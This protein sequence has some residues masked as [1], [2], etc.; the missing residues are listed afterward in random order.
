MDLVGT[1]T[2]T[3]RLPLRIGLDAGGL[4]VRGIRAGAHA[5]E[6]L[7]AGDGG[8]EPRAT[9]P[10]VER[11]PRSERRPRSQ[12]HPRTA[13]PSRP[14][15]AEPAEPV[16]PVEPAPA[17]PAATVPAEPAETVPAEPTETTPAE[18]AHVEEGTGL[19]AEFAERGAE[20]GAGAEVEL[21]EPWEGYDGMPA[22]E[23]IG[24]LD[25]SSAETLAAVTLYER[26]RDGRA[27]ILEQAELL[28]HRRIAPGPAGASSP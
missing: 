12:R 3:A 15:A 5:I 21:E 14:A 20:E 2:S 22:E 27:S 10:T 4:A 8:G 7:L 26:G 28:L 16:E 17:E 19:V 11:P 13:R 25:G 6:G 9:G 18:P 23:V 1:L 24:R